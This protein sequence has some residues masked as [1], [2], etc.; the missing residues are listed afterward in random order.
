MK[1][2]FNADEIFEMAE[3]IERQGAQFY[4]K[5]ASL[6]N[7][8]E[9]EQMLISL[10]GMEVGHEKLFSSMRSRILS[11]N[12]QGYDPDEMAAAYIKAFTDGKVFNVRKNMCD[13][14]SERTTL[15]DVLKM[16]IEAE[17]NSIV[18]YTGIKRL[19]PEALGQDTI[20][21]IIVEEM[22]HI[23]SLTDK[24]ASL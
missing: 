10:S 2:Y 21:K 15:R 9:I 12:Y 6:F 7:E 22:R 3:E 14:L 4:K 20:E 17:K 24:L 13:D 19:V 8:P 5:A 23:V 16:A 11:D 18:F 1:I